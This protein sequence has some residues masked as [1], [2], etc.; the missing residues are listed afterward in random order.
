MNNKFFS[1]NTTKIGLI[2]LSIF[3]TIAV[4]VPV[5]FTVNPVLAQNNISTNEAKKAQAEKLYNEGGQLY[6]EGSKKSLEQAMR[7]W[8]QALLLYQ[9]IKDRRGEAKTLNNIGLVYSELGDKQK[10]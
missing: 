3:G 8:K 7:K 5:N 6:K 9:K 2:V 10:A 1:Q 4:S